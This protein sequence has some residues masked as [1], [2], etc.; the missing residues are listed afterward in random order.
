MRTVPLA[1]CDWAGTIEEADDK[2]SLA[3]EVAEDI[4]ALTLALVDCTDVDAS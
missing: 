3:V 1:D 2:T 4:P